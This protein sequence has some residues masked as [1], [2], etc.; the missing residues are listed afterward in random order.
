MY[1][2]IFHEMQLDFYISMTFY[3]KIIICAVLSQCIKV[4]Y[5]IS[6][7]KYFNELI[8]FINGKC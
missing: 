1:I 5:L 4:T 6:G 3:V 8:L 2:I 7:F